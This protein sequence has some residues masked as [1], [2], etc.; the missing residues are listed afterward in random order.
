MALPEYVRKAV[1]QEATLVKTGGKAGLPSYVSEAV[2]PQ[3]EQPEEG[4]LG[5]LGERATKL[6][7][8]TGEKTGGSKLKATWELPTLMTVGAGQVAGGIGDIIATGL[9]ETYKA[10]T[11]E[12]IQNKIKET[13]G[14]LLS[15]EVGQ[16]GLMALEKGGK[17]YGAYKEAY[18]EQAMEL[19]SAVNIAFLGGGSKAAKETGK[20]VKSAAKEGID[21][22]TDVARLASGEALP[23]VLDN[24]LKN[25]VDA[26]VWKMIRPSVFTKKRPGQTKAY[27]DSVKEAV[28]TIVEN[29]NNLG[30]VDEFGKKIDRLPENLWE[31]SSAID[32]TKRLVY[33]QYDDMAKAAGAAP[34]DVTEVVGELTRLW[35]DPDVRL[36]NKSAAKKAGEIA[37]SLVQTPRTA[38]GIQKLIKELNVKLQPFYKNPTPGE[39]HG[40]A[41]L[42]A[43]VT[44]LRSALDDHI[45]KLEGVGYKELKRKYGALKAIEEEVGHRAIISARANQKGLMDFTDFYSGAQIMESLATGSPIAAAKGATVLSMKGIYKT[46]NDPNR[47]VKTMFKKADKIVQKMDGFEP[48]SKLGKAVKGKIEGVREDVSKLEQMKRTDDFINKPVPR[49]KIT[50]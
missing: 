23:R 22:T 43:T 33:R 45:T 36:L 11:P 47:F 46:L 38:E 20:V 2:S 49:T 7:E 9:T 39:A 6:R 35:K 17:V 34:V 13:A 29:K 4:L 27:L 12:S 44:R 16:L 26:N 1:D 15:T 19:E 10:I 42:E 31:L 8:Y 30:L 41:I 25:V 21:I 18:P 24:Q 3:E 32:N 14:E 5:R 37:E 40:A 28:K 50:E 48:K